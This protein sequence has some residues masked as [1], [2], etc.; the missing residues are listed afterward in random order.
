MRSPRPTCGPDCFAFA[1]IRD[2]DAV[3][4]NFLSVGQSGHCQNRSCRRAGSNHLPIDILQRRLVVGIGE[5]DVD[6]HDVLE[7]HSG[8]AQHGLDLVHGFARLTGKVPGGASLTRYIKGAIR[9]QAGAVG[10]IGIRRLND[11]EATGLGRERY[12]NGQEQQVTEDVTDH[13][14][15]YR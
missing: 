5:I 6:P 7:I 15:S 4:L 12:S 14:S 13:E 2:C 8:S 10:R 3:D 9:E 1:G 11:L